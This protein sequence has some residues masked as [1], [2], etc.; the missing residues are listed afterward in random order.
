MSHMTA[1]IWP[2]CRWLQEK[3]LV[4]M[5]HRH[6]DAPAGLGQGAHSL[7]PRK[8]NPEIVTSLLSMFTCLANAAGG[9]KTPNCPEKRPS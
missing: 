4:G 6:P 5:A 2:P 7:A 9:E 1:T 3:G 8:P